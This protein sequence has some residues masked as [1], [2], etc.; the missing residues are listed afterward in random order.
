MGRAHLDAFADVV[1]DFAAGAEVS[2]LPA[3]LDYLDT[4]E[5]AEDGFA[6]GEVDVAP[7]RVQVLTVHAAK[8]LE[9]EIVAVPHLVEE[10]FPGRKISG[11]WLTDPSALPVPLRGDAA[12]LPDLDLPAPGSDR[13]AVE[14]ALTAHDEALDDRRLVEERRLFYVALTRAERVLLLSGHRWGPTGERPRE[15]SRFLGE[16]RAARR[17]FGSGPGGAL[18]GGAGAGRE[19]GDGRTRHGRVAGGP[20]RGPVRRRAR[21]CRA[22]PGGAPRSPRCG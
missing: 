22:G 12:D 13:K 14:A 21:R 7:G 6:P 3:L 11:S 15:P 16:M 1:A 19:P 18:G 20:A 10:V 2:T 8:G 17:R 4:A 9:W 5:R